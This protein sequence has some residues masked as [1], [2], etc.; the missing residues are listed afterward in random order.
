MEFSVVMWY[1]VSES[2]DLQSPASHEGSCDTESTKEI[3][4][5]EATAAGGKRIEEIAGELV[6]VAINNAVIEIQ[7][8]VL[9]TQIYC[10][11]LLEY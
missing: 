5:V 3:V 9:K 10:M 1:A 4:D 11:K 7:H 2:G 8:E 6:T